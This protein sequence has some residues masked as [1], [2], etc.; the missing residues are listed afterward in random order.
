M[1]NV[2]NCLIVIKK[3]LQNILT[4]FQRGTAKK[5]PYFCHS[6]RNI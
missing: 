2:I 1:K 6:F 3:K 5:C 4:I